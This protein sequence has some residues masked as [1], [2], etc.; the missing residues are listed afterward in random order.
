MSDHVLPVLIQI[1]GHYESKR[2]KWMDSIEATP[3]VLD[4]YWENQGWNRDAVVKTMSRIDAPE[5]GAIV[6]GSTTVAGIAFAGVRGIQRVEISTNGGQSWADA[7]LK[8]PLSPL[9]WTL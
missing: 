6:R 4:G 8:P 1:T 7:E 2:P 9:T 5:D 3:R